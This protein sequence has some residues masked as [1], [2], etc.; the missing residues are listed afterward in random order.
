MSKSDRNDL[1]RACLGGAMI[2]LILFSI[3]VL[4]RGVSLHCSEAQQTRNVAPVSSEQF[5]QQFPG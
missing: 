2:F 3:L 1:V 4:D 5:W